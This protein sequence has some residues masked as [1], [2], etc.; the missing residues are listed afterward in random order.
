LGISN[1][2]SRWNK[3]WILATAASFMVYDL[4]WI[5]GVYTRIN[6]ILLENLPDITAKYSNFYVDHVA[7]GIADTLRLVAVI[8][9]FIAVYLVW[10]PKKQP[11]T[12]VKKYVAISIVFEAI[13]WLAILPYNLESI[14]RARSPLLLYAGFAAQ[15]I[16]A[17]IPLILLSAKVWKYQGEARVNLVKWGCLAGI[18]YIFGMWINHSFRWISMSG[19]NGLADLLSGITALGFLNTVVTL[20]LSLVF[21]IA[22]SY[23]LIRRRNRKLAMSLLGSAVFLFGLYF[24]FYIVYAW[25]APNAWRFVL[26]TEIWPVPL[27]GLGI[28]ILKRK[29][30]A[31]TLI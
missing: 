5:R 15:I 8:L 12:A 17:A 13:Y 10:G 18:G 14:V 25:F 26:L 30:E 23:I 24:A 3:A 22:G 6:A 28:G 16:V 7:G 4:Y 2:V 20:T 1:A 31:A 19:Q 27:L 21:A 11:F 9:L 29:T